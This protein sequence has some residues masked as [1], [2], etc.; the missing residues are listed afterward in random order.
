[1]KKQGIEIIGKWKD[2]LIGCP[3]QCYLKIKYLDKKYV[4]YLRW[5][6]HDPWTARIYECVGD[7]NMD[8]PKNKM[9]VLHIAFFTD[10]QL[11]ALK[12][13]IV[14]FV[15]NCLIENDFSNRRSPI[16]GYYYTEINNYFIKHL[17][18]MAD[19]V[20]YAWAGKLYEYYDKLLLN[21]AEYQ[22]L[23]KLL[24]IKKKTLNE[25][26][27]SLRVVSEKKIKRNMSETVR[28]KNQTQDYSEQFIKNFE[29]YFCIKKR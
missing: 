21:R 17:S 23:I 26:N 11:P 8:D 20:I 25:I 29:K 28:E 13:Y 10:K 14:R 27:R 24:Q 19:P 12:R 1:M 6:H 18:G 22:K 9:T 7:W 15:E 2:S 16:N 3:S 5:R 4:M